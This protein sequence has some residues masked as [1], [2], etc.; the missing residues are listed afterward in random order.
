MASLLGVPL[1]I[2]EWRSL[3]PFV[4]RIGVGIL[5][6]AI[7]VQ[8]VSVVLPHGLEVSQALQWNGDLFAV[9]QRIVN[10]IAIATGNY[11][12]WNLS[13][14]TIDELMAWNHLPHFTPFN[15]SQQL[16][17]SL[18]KVLLLGWV[19]L[20]FIW[21]ITLITVLSALRSMNSENERSVTP[22]SNDGSIAPCG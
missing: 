9:K 17:P 11:Y 4:R 7:L 19:M 21:V 5:L 15:L 14:H 1:L 16:S 6:M 8:I 12:Q 10:I 22:V 18:V 13:T 3:K 2:Q 20:I